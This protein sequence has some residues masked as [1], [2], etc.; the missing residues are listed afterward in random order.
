MR[1]TPPTL[2]IHVAKAYGVAPAAKRAPVQAAEAAARIEPR[3]DSAQT[4]A[5][6]LVAGVVPGGIDF[7]GDQPVPSAPSH[8]LYRHPADR[9]AA[10]TAVHAGRVLDLE[11]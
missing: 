10:A 5:N 4:T 1:I 9:N 8:Q 7:S 11:G 2:P 6:P 3:V